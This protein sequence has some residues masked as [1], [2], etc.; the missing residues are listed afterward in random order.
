MGGFASGL[1]H[2][3]YGVG[4]VAGASARVMVHVA[5]AVINTAVLAADI[6]SAIPPAVIVTPPLAPA[7]EYPV[8]DA[9][10]DSND[11]PAN[12]Q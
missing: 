12:D 3:A 7:S 11:V 5:P 9:V 1:G 8:D 10:D 6:A 2:L 4:K